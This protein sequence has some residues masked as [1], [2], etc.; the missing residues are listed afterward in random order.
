MDVGVIAD[1]EYSPG[2]HAVQAAAPAVETL[3]P[4]HAAHTEAPVEALYLPPA[5]SLHTVAEAPP[6][7][8]FPQLQQLPGSVLPGTAQ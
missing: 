6:E 1:A 8:A 7:G 3:P 4:A 5:Q 2:A